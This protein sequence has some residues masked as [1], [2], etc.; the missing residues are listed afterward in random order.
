MGFNFSEFKVKQG[1]YEAGLL[2]RLEP[3]KL[4]KHLA[5]I[6]DGNGRWAARRGL[7]RIEGH[8]R[9][10]TSV[11]RLVEDCRRLGIGV[12]TIY[13]FSVE[14]W[15]RPQKEIDALMAMLSDF[16]RKEINNLLKNEIRFLPYGRWRELPTRTVAD[17][18]WAMEETSDCDKMLFQ[19]ALNYGGRTEL[20]DACRRVAEDCLQGQLNAEEIDEGTISERLYSPDVPDPD[21][22]IRTSGEMRVSNFLL[23]EI[24]YTELHITELHWPDFRLRHLLEALIDFQ[25]RERRFGGLSGEGK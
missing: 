22:L 15:K 9:G 17:L 11:R 4:P 8:R 19:V 1:S 5:V 14:N 24:A 25:M 6:M 23:W 18:E 20:V 13:A 3:E 12:L 21:L 7:P 16:V 10:A 2:E